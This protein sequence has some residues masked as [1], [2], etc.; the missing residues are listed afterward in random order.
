MIPGEKIWFLGDVEDSLRVRFQNFTEAP[1]ITAAT[2]ILTND[3]RQV[4]IA[5]RG[6]LAE[7][8]VVCFLPEAPFEAFH[9]PDFRDVRQLVGLWLATTTHSRRQA[10]ALRLPV[11]DLA[12]GY[13]QLQAK[14]LVTPESGPVARRAFLKRAPEKEGSMSKGLRAIGL[15]PKRHEGLTVSMFRE[16]VKPPFGGANQFML[17]LKSAF[18]AQGVRVLVNEVGEHIH[19]YYFDSLWFDEKLLRK[20]EKIQDPVVIHRIDGPIHLYRGKDKEL[21]DRIFEINARLA[22]STVIQSDFT[23]EKLVETGYRPVRPVVIRNAVNPSIFHPVSREK[24]LS[25]RKVRLIATSWS[26]NPNKGGPVY[27]WLE[28]NLDWSRYEFTFVGRCSETLSKARVEEPVPSE[29]L[30]ALLNDHDIYVTA[31]QNDPCSNAL[32]EALS[33]GLPAVA[34]RSGGHPELVGAGGLTFE[35]K[36]EIPSLLDRISSGYEEFRAKVNPPRMES[37]SE[38][39]LRL[40]KEP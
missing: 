16:F 34:L 18:E 15:K 31:S 22:T 13:D 3:W 9:D 32:V 20:L 6:S 35:R 7:K 2:I 21:D 39:Y 12:D 11:Y 19:G 17:A 1:H 36:E 40:V 25:G 5:D 26:D 23:L 24:S 27:K 10:E 14:V 33:C 29:R 28:E 37:V 38:L 30:A 8:R 4:S